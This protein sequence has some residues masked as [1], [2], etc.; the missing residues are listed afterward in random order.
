[1][2]EQLFIRAP[3]T[4]EA[5]FDWYLPREGCGRGG[6]EALAEALAGRQPVLL[7]PGREV[8]H[9]AA[10]VPSRRRSLI[11][12]A[13]PHLVEEQLAQDLEEL[14]FAF[15]REANGVVPLCVL[16]RARLAA[17]LERLETHGVRPQL[18]VGENS[19]VPAGEL[20][21]DG[22]SFH[23]NALGCRLSLALELLPEL[24]AGCAAHRSA[25][26]EETSVILRYPEA[27]EA[28]L[29]PLIERIRATTGL[30]LQPER[31]ELSPFEFLCRQADLKAAVNLLQGDFA[32]TGPG[33]AAVFR[34]VFLLAC[35]ALLLHTAIIA[36]QGLVFSLAGEALDERA[37][38]IHLEV[39]PDERV[40][41][42]LPRVWEAKLAGVAASGDGALP[43]LLRQLDAQLALAGLRLD[44]F[45]FDSRRDPG[46]TRLR[47]S[48]DSGEQLVAFTE[49]L[50]KDGLRAELEGIE[51]QG[52]E[53][54]LGRV[55]ISRAR[56][57]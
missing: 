10:R 11:R 42:D 44:R 21:V 23:I 40:P 17:Y 50:A 26:D 41:R 45:D 3:E 20:L 39:F 27:Q 6:P 33:L 51:Q 8:L 16:A 36:G 55:G 34:P 7:L 15:G 53:G 5:G 19:C 30:R 22:D 47:L 35:L 32:G 9:T 4:G 46:E 12:Q 24:L 48:A 43:E 18:A 56:R 49:A 13:A 1:M 2:A 14:H 38:A 57:P 37:R 29:L 54:V 25:D 31:L 28:G 52:E